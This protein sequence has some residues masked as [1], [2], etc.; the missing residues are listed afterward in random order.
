MTG[1]G[2]IKYKNGDEYIGQFRFGKR[3]GKGTFIWASG[4][5]YIGQFYEDLKEGAG[6]SQDEKGKATYH[7]WQDDK[8]I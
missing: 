5:K 7:E 1:Q 3:H 4:A 6:T 2:T 8:Q